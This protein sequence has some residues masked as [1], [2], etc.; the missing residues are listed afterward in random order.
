MR[1]K[2]VLSVGDSID[3]VL[4]EVEGRGLHETD[5]VIKS[6]TGILSC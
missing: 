2:G 1:R 3:E 4:R 5:I 6:W